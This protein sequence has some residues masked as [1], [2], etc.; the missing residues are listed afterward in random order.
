VVSLF[1]KECLVTVRK[2]F[3]HHLHFVAF[4]FVKRFAL[5]YRTFVPSVCLSVCPVLSV[6]L[7]HCGQTVGWIKMKLGVQVGLG[8][9]HIVLDGDPS[10]LPQRGTASTQFSAHI[11]CSQIA[12]WIK[13]PLG[14]ELG[15]SPGDFVLDGDPAPFPRKG[16][17]PPSP[18]FGPFLLWPNGWMHQDATWYEGRPQP[19]GLCVTWGPS[20]LNFRPMFIIVIV[21]SS[22]H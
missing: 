14:M 2:R 11:C 1:V 8:P 12:A 21:I 4:S 17:E 3:W 5:C 22:E 18:T 15:L 20:P 6:M 9:G 19:R 16:A 10:P 7:V 13:M